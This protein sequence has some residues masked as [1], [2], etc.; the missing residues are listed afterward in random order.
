ML[1]RMKAAIGVVILL[2]KVKTISPSLSWRHSYS[3]SFAI[4]TLGRRVEG[5]RQANRGCASMEGLWT[6]LDDALNI[7]RHGE[8]VC[9]SNT[10]NFK[11]VLERL[12][13]NNSDGWLKERL[14][15]LSAN[16]RLQPFYCGL[17]SGCWLYYEYLANSSKGTTAHNVS[18]MYCEQPFCR[19]TEPWTESFLRV[20]TGISINQF[21][22]F[23]TVVCKWHNVDLKKCTFGLIRRGYIIRNRTRSISAQ[24]SVIYTKH[25][26]A[27]SNKDIFMLCYVMYFSRKNFYRKIDLR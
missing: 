14:L 8:G 12:I 15:L 10:N 22:G 1:H 5:L 9:N 11:Y 4:T 25:L 7:F 19:V 2:L 17:V 6:G 16:T 26:A 3:C 20:R 27:T 24:P 23:C 13:S 21:T 18:V